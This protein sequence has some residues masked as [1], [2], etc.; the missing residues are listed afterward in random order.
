[1]IETENILDSN[2]A[3]ISITQFKT[4]YIPF[5]IELPKIKIFNT[6]ILPL[7]IHNFE[8]PLFSGNDFVGGG[9]ANLARFGLHAGT[10][11]S[12]H[13]M[14]DEYTLYYIILYYI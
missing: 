14:K 8:T 5:P 11:N 12:V 13:R 6:I 2:L 3:K 10:G 1:V 9:G 4:C 7:A